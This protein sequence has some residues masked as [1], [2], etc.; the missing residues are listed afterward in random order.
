[1]FCRVSTDSD[2][3]QVLVVPAVDC[4]NERRLHLILRY[5]LSPSQAFPLQQ[6]HI[7]HWMRLASTAQ[8]SSQQYTV[9]TKIRDFVI[10]NS[11]L[12]QDRQ[13]ASVQLQ[14]VPLPSLCSRNTLYLGRDWSH[15]SEQLSTVDHSYQD[16]RSC[17]WQLAAHPRQTVCFGSAPAGS[18]AFH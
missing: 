2:G 10:G 3:N 1:M 6:N 5:L 4:Q 16:Q 7:K 13:S 17:Y 12:I 9:L 18:V 14:Q 11:Q 15:F 8:S